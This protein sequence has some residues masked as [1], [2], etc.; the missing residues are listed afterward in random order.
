M[1][2]NNVHFAIPIDEYGGTDGIVTIE[3]LIEENVGNIFD[4]YD[5]LK[6]R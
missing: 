3:D 2:K 1:Q 5:E 4:E 6:R